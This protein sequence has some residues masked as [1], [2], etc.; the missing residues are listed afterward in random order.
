LPLSSAKARSPTI[1]SAPDSLVKKTVFAAEQEREDVRLAREAWIREQPSLLAERLLFLDETGL[2]TKFAR[3]RA[4]SLRGQR[5]VGHAPHGHW[6]SYTAIMAL[7]YDRMCAPCVFDGP[8]NGELF[9]QY[10]RQMLAPQL[11][12]GDIL[13]CDKLATHYNAEAKKLIEERGA[14]LKFLP[15]YSPDLNPIEP[16]F[17]QLK[18]SL[19]AAA[20]RAHQP[21]MDAIRFALKGFS[22]SICS[23][24]FNHAN[25]ATC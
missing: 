17:S 22:S 1:S 3:L 23:N 21:L 13:I 10:V 24:Y 16:A 19:R 9:V 8:M 11:K 2:N 14:R 6:K 15:P 7:G 20:P 4:R 18:S 12:P 5:C 25:Y